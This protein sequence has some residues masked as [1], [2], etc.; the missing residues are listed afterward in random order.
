M[1]MQ[2]LVFSAR[3][4]FAYAAFFTIFV[5][6]M[7]PSMVAMAAEHETVFRRLPKST[8]AAAVTTNASGSL[9]GFLATGVVKAFSGTAFEPFFSATHAL[10]PALDPTS[11]LPLPWQSAVDLLDDGSFAVAVLEVEDQLP[12][13]IAMLEMRGKRADWAKLVQKHAE[14][15]KG[16]KEVI[17]KVEIEGVKAVVFTSSAEPLNH[18]L[19]CMVEDW[20]YICESEGAFRLLLAASQAENQENLK[21]DQRYTQI[22]EKI[23]KQEISDSAL[24]VFADPL[25]ADFLQSRAGGWPGTDIAKTFGARNGFDAIRSLGGWILFG[26]EEYDIRYQFHFWIGQPVAKGMKLLDFQ[27][28]GD[29]APSPWVPSRN[30]SSY[31]SIGWNLQPILDHAGPLVNEL[32]EDV[33]GKSE[34]TFERFLKQIEADDGPGVN[35]QKQLM[36]LLG[37]R[38]EYIS[39]FLPPASTKA[40]Q[41]VIAIEL[42]SS[43]PDVA[44]E[45]ADVIELLVDSGNTLP[46]P[47][48]GFPYPLW[49]MGSG[50]RAGGGPSFST[51]GVMVAHNRLFIA[52]NFNTI[53]Q[54][55]AVVDVAEKLGDDKRFQ[56][57]DSRLQEIAGTTP[58]LRI[59]AF[60]ADDFENSYELMRTGRAEQAESVY[61][62]LLRPLLN[63]NQ[64]K[65]P[66]EKLPSFSVLK[67]ALGPAGIQLNLSENG[68]TVHGIN[69]RVAK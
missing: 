14:G 23:G 30:V 28:R 57:V 55:I 32:V 65:L 2:S 34:E 47:I 41:S 29:A 5:T 19:F 38:L 63:K 51:P 3:N 16:R 10:S 8:V 17:S 56:Q 43:A 49:K 27:A 45:V 53:R 33:T 24:W 40:E 37:E 58:A 15:A 62:M 48:A 12:E 13:L 35:L 26:E 6:T 11:L 61:T 22:F 69:L 7:S 52:S 50:Q 46:I 18:Y 44:V 1:K 39:L 64:N 9:S 42:N 60:P 4:L 67:N 54:A 66:F 59:V 31:A 21:G 25:R 36:P 68:W 20:L